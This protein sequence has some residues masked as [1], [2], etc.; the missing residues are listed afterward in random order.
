[1]LF[2]DR[3]RYF[4]AIGRQR[5][6]SL[7]RW[8]SQFHAGFHVSDAT[9]GSIIPQVL[10]FRYRAITC[11]GRAFQSRSRRHDL[12]TK[13]WPRNTTHVRK[14]GWFGLIPVRSPLLRESRLL[15]FPRATEMFHFARFASAPYDPPCGGASDANDAA[16]AAPGCPIRKSRDLSLF[17]GS[18]GLIAAFHVLHRLLAPRHPPCTLGSLTLESPSVGARHLHPP[19]TPLLFTFQRASYQQQPP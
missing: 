10:P 9:R 4:C 1:M 13:R 5:V 15:S 12:Q 6:L 16:F 18:P 3:S 2:I 7:G 14:R 17:G 8:S 19:L 11:S